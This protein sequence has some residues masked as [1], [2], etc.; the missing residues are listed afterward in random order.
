MI[1]GCVCDVII[2]RTEVY[3]K[4]TSFKQGFVSDLP[5]RRS[6]THAD[7]FSAHECFYT[8]GEVWYRELCS[9]LTGEFTSEEEVCFISH[10][11]RHH[12]DGA[13]HAIDVENNV[14]Q[15]HPQEVVHLRCCGE[16][17]HTIK[18]GVRTWLPHWGICVLDAELIR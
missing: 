13:V 15:V 12:V 11:G 17:F 10:I 8:V 4:N 1:Q 7:V 2:L 18:R 14:L 16:D 6:D 3:V 9:A 5:H